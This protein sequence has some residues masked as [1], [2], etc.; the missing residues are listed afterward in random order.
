MYYNIHNTH[1]FQYIL[2]YVQ[3]T[4]YMFSLLS[5]TSIYNLWE[6]ILYMY[7]YYIKINLPL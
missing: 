4:N 5:F 3:H 1:I 2:R 6:N 7:M